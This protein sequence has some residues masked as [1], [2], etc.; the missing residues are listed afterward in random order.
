MSCLTSS[1]DPL[2]LA[3]AR[4]QAVITIKQLAQELETKEQQFKAGLDPVVAKVLKPKRILLWKSLLMAANYDDLDIVDL[5]SKG[6]PLT[7]SHGKVPAL[8]EKIVPS[9]DSHEALLASAK[10]RRRA[11]LAR[12]RDPPEKEQMD[13]Q[14]ASDAEV[15]RGE[16]EGPFTEQQII[17][18][19]TTG[20]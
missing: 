7:G 20:S 13:L 14:E 3:K 9:T 1:R 6:I 5:V 19:Q 10:L 12:R 8:P 15:L 16:A 18:A 17:L 2:D 4:I 11:I